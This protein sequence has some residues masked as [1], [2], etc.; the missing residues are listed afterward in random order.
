MN[1]RNH[2]CIISEAITYDFI[3]VGA[4]TAGSIVAS[5]LAEKFT[6]QSVLLIESG[7]DPGPD[8]EVSEAPVLAFSFIQVKVKR[9]A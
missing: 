8:S 6:S 5:G 9:K 7:E 2:K 3:V 1:S 4:G